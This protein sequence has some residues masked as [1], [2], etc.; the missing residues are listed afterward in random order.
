MP[1]LGIAL[2]PEACSESLDTSPQGKAPVSGVFPAGVAL[3]LL[4]IRVQPIQVS[5]YHAGLPRGR[6]Y[7]WAR[8]AG[9]L[10]CCCPRSVSGPGK[11]SGPGTNYHLHSLPAARGIQQSASW[12]SK[13]RKDRITPLTTGT[14]AVL[15]TW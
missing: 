12:R 3:H 6:P 10:A 8:P 1:S 2:S 11:A 15:R 13:G 14:I 7:A 9:F 4:E 5:P